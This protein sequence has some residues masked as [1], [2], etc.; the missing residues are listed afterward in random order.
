MAP[1]NPVEAKPK[2]FSV[3][4]ANKALPLVK[5]IVGD[6]VRQFQVVN[7]LKQRL[8][9][10]AARPPTA[11]ERPLRRGDRPEPG[12]A[13][14]RGGE[15]RVRFIDE[16]T[17]ARR[18]AEGAR[19]PLRLPQP[20]RRPR[21]LPLLAARRARGHP[22]A[23]DRTPASPAA[24]RST[25]LAEDR[26]PAVLIG[27]ADRPARSDSIDASPSSRF[28]STAR[29]RNSSRPGRSLV[30]PRP[31]RSRARVGPDPPRDRLIVVEVD[32]ALEGRRAWRSRGWSRSTGRPG[33]A[34]ARSPVGSP[35]G[36]AGGCSTP[37]P[38]TGPSPW[39]P[40]AR[41]ST[42]RATTPSA[43]LV[44]TIDVALPPGR[45]LLDGEDVSAVIRAVEVTRVD[46]PRRRQPERPPTA[47]RLAAGLR[48]GRGRASSPKGATRGRSSSPTPSAS[49]SSPPATRS[50]PAVAT[51]SSSR[52][53]S[54][55]RFETV[56]GDLLD[57][58]AQD[59]ARAIAPM[60]PAD[61]ARI[62]DSTG[63][64]LDQRRRPDRGGDP[65]STA[66]DRPSPRADER[67][68]GSTRCPTT[69]RPRRLAATRRAGPGPTGA[70]DRSPPDRLVS[71]R[72]VVLQH[73][74][75]RAFY[76]LRATGRKN[77]PKSGAGCC[78]SRTT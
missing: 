19:R 68:R 18:R 56:L 8:A 17:P 61:D 58:D 50:E 57:R 65:R 33:R 52:G 3:E 44:A 21:G 45:V 70:T 5:A 26:A 72:P 41:A 42:S 4:E 66:A 23:R 9:A 49:S 38:C 62:I 30:D 20:P 69:D 16:L 11:G 7:E 78:W 53:A 15:A 43:S 2:F 1:P 24:S 25:A 47:R 35:T 14:G 59:A 10:V 60:R 64:D 22:L 36:W 12:R 67:S 46:P 77:I 29:P 73:D 51:P 71:V 74:P 55:S 54:R 28:I 76:G 27:P 31:L 40:S 39:P 34:R 48:R 32:W 13:G 75:A 6:I 37:G 63:L